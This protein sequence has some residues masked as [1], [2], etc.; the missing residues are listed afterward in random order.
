MN[1]KSRETNKGAKN[2]GPTRGAP[3]ETYRSRLGQRAGFFRCQ[4]NRRR[5]GILGDF[6]H[7]LDLNIPM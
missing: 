2:G 5:G 3:F 4:I 1:A 6:H 7:R